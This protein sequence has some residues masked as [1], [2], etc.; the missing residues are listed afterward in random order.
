MYPGSDIYGGL[1]NAWDYGPYGSVLKKNIADA[2]WKFFV[3]Q[4]DD[5]VGM[6][7]QILMHP[8]VWEASGHVGNFNDPMIDDKKTGERFRADKLIEEHIED[9]RASF[10]EQNQG[11]FQEY[12]KDA[13]SD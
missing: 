9:C 10:L 2:R 3:Q 4:R 8:R 11:D 13:D 6:D 7:S 12:Y 1:A 5:M